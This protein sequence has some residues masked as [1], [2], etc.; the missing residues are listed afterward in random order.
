M[1]KMEVDVKLQSGLESKMAA[2]FIQKT[3][4]FKSS[5]YITNG[6]RKANAKSL[7]GV[8]SLAISDGDRVTIIA[9]GEDE[10]EALKELGK[11][12]QSV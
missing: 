11:Y 1:G 5:I 2:L 9:E 3:S 7:L 4:E 10:N 12:L 6:E 8:L